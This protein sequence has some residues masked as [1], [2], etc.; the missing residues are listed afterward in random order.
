MC[1]QCE[2]PV[3]ETRCDH[4]SE[5]VRTSYGWRHIKILD[6]SRAIRRVENEGRN[7]NG[8]VYYWFYGKSPNQTGPRGGRAVLQLHPAL[9]LLY[10]RPVRSS[11]QM[12]QRR[13]EVHS[14]LLM[15]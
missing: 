12:P 1:E 11:V 9:N 4:Q 6:G 14:E 10:H 8:E 15:G 5:Q 3:Q 13:P 2:H 7:S